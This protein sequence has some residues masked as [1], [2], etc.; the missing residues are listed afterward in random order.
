MYME[1]TRGTEET[2]IAEVLRHNG[3]ESNLGR[4]GEVIVIPYV[5]EC[6]EQPT[7]QQN[8]RSIRSRLPASE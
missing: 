3:S 1:V 2:K 4:K 8:G 5:L 6:P 7:K